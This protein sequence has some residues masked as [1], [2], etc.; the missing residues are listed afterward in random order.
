MSRR[1]KEATIRLDEGSTAE[2]RSL[3]P[4][5]ELNLDI[6]IFIGGLRYLF[7]IITCLFFLF[8]VETSFLYQTGLNSASRRT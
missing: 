5:S 1:S 8:F 7:Y 6:P 4:L 2:G 3:G